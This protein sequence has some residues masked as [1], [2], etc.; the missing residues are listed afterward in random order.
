MCYEDLRERAVGEDCADDGII[1]KNRVPGTGR[2]STSEKDCE[3]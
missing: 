3:N 1:A 2:K